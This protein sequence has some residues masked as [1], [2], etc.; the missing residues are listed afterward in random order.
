MPVVEVSP[1]VEGGQ[2]PAKAAVGEVVPIN[3][4]IFRE[5]HDLVGANAVLVAPDGTDHSWARMR[6]VSPGN[7]RYE[8]YLQPDDEGEWAFRVEAWSDP[9]GTWEHDAG[10][11]IN[12]GVDVDLMLNEGVLLFGRITAPELQATRTPEDAATLA[13]AAAALADTSKTAPLR[14]AQATSAEVW[15]AMDRQPLRDLISPSA[16]YPLRVSRRRALFGSWYEIFPRSEG[17]ERLPDGTWKSGTLQTAQKRLPDIA[18]MGFDVIYLT[19]IHP[20]GSQFKKGKNNSLDSVP[21]D[22][23]SPYAIGSADGG[24]DAIHPDLGTEADFKDFVAAAAKS[25]ME[26][27]IDLA[28]QCS[29]DHP[30]VTEHPEWFKTRA[31]GSIAYAENPPKKYQDIYPLYFDTDPIGLREEILRVLKHWIDLGVTIFRVDNPHT[32][33]LDFW[34]WLLNEIHSTN[35]EILFLAEAFTNPAMMATLARIGFHQSYT[36]FT[37]RNGKDEILE[38]FAEVAGPGG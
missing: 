1:V 13:A 34:Q 18:A 25:G 27:C 10:V 21:S 4:T 28:L 30:W 8:G 9:F 7:N 3:A 26:T 15:A 6:D 14:F 5:G 20:I 29:P 22:P 2:F 38:Y 32:K 33:P 11:K 19:P 35:P 17:A 31:D 16:T 37:W 36:Y 24:H 12:A 23:G